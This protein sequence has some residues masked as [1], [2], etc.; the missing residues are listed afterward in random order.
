MFIYI[1]IRQ[2]KE[3]ER[4]TSV[5]SIYHW[6]TTYSHS[7]DNICLFSLSCFSHF[8]VFHRLDMV[9]DQTVAPM[10]IHH[11]IQMNPRRTKSDVVV[12]VVVVLIDD[13]WVEWMKMILDNNLIK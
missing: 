11:Q 12:V 5:L 4:E 6:D 3:R 10:F 2:E 7:L 13:K 9:T 1:V 8:Y